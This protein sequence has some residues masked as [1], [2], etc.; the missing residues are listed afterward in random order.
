MSQ[1]VS[2]TDVAS[3]AV[4]LETGLEAFQQSREFSGPVEALDGH[5]CN[6]HFAHIYET[7][8]EKFEA[9]VPFVRH[10]LERGERI[11]YVVDQSTEAEVQQTLR[12]A[13]I[14]VDAAL[15]SGALEFY[16]VAETYLRSG[17]FDQHEMI[18]FYADA[19]SEATEEFEALR[20][21][22]EMS[23]IKEDETTI[24]QLMEYESKIN[25][26]FN[27]ED[28]L[29]ICQYDR[30]LFDPELIQNVIRTHPHLIYNGAAC[31]NFY[32]T[33]PEEL[34]GDNAPV[35]ENERMLQ[36]LRERTTAKVELQQREQF[37]KDLYEVTADSD[38]LFETK[39]RGLLE[40]GS[41]RFGLEIGYFAQTTADGMYDIVE[42]VGDHDQITAG[43]TDSL[44][45]TYCEKLLAA[46][47][48]IAVTD[49][50][51]VGW[52][53]DRAYERFGLDAYF[54]TAVHVSGEEYGT[55]CFASQTPREKPYTDAERTYLDLMGQWIE[56]ELERQQR[57][58]FLQESYQITADPDLAFE[59]KLEQLLEF[60]REWMGLETAGLT[61]LPSWD[62][63]FR[64]DF[65]IGY[66][67]DMVDDS[68]TL[69]TDPGDGCYCRQAIESDEP[70]GMADVRGTDWEDDKI[71]QEYGLSCYLGT[72]VMN[73]TTPYGTLWVGSTEPRDHEFT[74]TE[75]TFLE[76]MGQWVSY[77]IE[78]EHRES[79][80]RESN[81]RLEQFAYAASHDLQ[82]PLRMVS[83]YLQLIE[84]RYG[85]EFDEDG[86]EF[87]EFAVD[88]ADRMRRMIDGLLAYSRVETRGDP[89]EPV[90]LETVLDD[91]REDLQLQIEDTDT[92][93]T[94]EP[95]PCVEGDGD[96][97]RQV[98]QNLLENAITYSGD[99]TPRIYLD[100]ER[101]KHEWVLSVHDNGIGIEP[102]NQDR[103]FDIF[104]RLHSRDEYD[105]TGLGLALCQRIVERHGG[106]MWIDSEPGEGATFS[107]TLPAIA[108]HEQ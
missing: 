30:E 60:G 92:T 12:T 98:L 36:T 53:T 37:L 27:H 74:E 83:S 82:E 14:D 4:T 49:A 71:Y 77:E 38:R 75:H 21:V 105:G 103:V 23:W 79:A 51:E 70:V 55:L 15:E 81:K 25:D 35:R 69:W 89:L 31:H 61:H 8:S 108:D 39:V 46:P 33:P 88:G 68:D 99:A 94:A 32:Y 5:D 59:T 90:E 11:A 72:K 45:D 91:V 9:A 62:D 78:R 48:R 17:T 93:I 16:T 63:R 40:L 97:L 3:D 1:N 43:S 107:L 24:E 10:G 64:N 50:A 104:N 84:Q 87:L 101:R 54:A 13:G 19:T 44:S 73:G 100:A 80:L 28:V 7:S 58:E 67:G 2:P 26:L 52:T 6:D 95:L 65:T 34:F 42:A 47:G 22:A 41:E 102:E 86:E 85:E 18:Q 29:A 56:Y 96:Q 66:W 57:E 106:K 76:L 20:L